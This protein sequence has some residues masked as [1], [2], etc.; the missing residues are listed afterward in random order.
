MA[1]SL[2]RTLSLAI[3]DA[4]FEQLVADRTRS[5][6]DDTLV[7]QVTITRR[8]IASQV[9]QL[10]LGEIDTCRSLLIEFDADVDLRVGAVDA[11]ATRLAPISAGQTGVAYFECSAAAGIWLE[12]P[13]ATAA[14]NVTVVAAGEI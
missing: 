11:D 9:L 6:R 8:L 12:N 13:S 3:G 1:L 10:D 4:D 2:K 7:A 14:V 5:I